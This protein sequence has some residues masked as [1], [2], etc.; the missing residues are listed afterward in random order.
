MRSTPSLVRMAIVIAFVIAFVQ[1]LAAQLPG[2]G[3]DQPS[4]EFV[5]SS[6]FVAA[7]LFPK[8]IASNPSLKLFPM[9][10]VTAWGKKEFGFDPLLILQAT[11]IMEPPKPPGEFG[12]PSWAAVLS[13]EKMQG[14]TGGMIDQLEKKTIAGKTVFSGLKQGTPSFLVFDESTII[15]GEETLFEKLLV[16]DGTG[17]LVELFKHPNVKGQ[18]LVTV[19]VVAMR[20]LIEELLNSS[21]WVENEKSAPLPPAMADLKLLPNLLESIEFG[22]N[23]ENTFESTLV[24]HATDS[25]AAKRAGDIVVKAMEFGAQALVGQLSTSLDLNDPVEAATIQYAER[26]AI[27]YQSNLTPIVT[28]SQLKIT[29][30]E[31]ILT[32]P[33]LASLL[34]SI[35][36]NAGPGQAALTS[37]GQLRQTALAIHNYES[38]YG[39]LPPHSIDDNNGKPLLSGR[40]TLLPFIGQDAIYNS[41]KLDEPWNSTH[42]L[43]FS[44]IAVPVFGLDAT[45][46]NLATVRFPVYPNSIWD[47]DGGRNFRDVTDGLSNTVVAFHAPPGESIE[48]SDPA[49][50]TLSRTDPMAD[51]FGTRDEVLAVMLDGST[52]VLKKSDMTNEKLK[53]LLTISGG[54]VIQE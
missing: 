17:K 33:F 8:K 49:P 37:E 23:I 41:L 39:K 36:S 48:W 45:N 6:A 15:V 47:A 40:V 21:D 44:Q 9:E 32:A 4:P 51:V 46:N 29:L 2:R 1:P 25:E 16:A 50:W 5:P 34:G 7:V 18:T 43:P 30:H 13:F 19:D 3:D 52:R 28:G 54:E 12:R 38:A 26:M 22:L 10:V 14:L 31:E 42:N 11:W 24:L 53:A 27:K 20:P 35:G